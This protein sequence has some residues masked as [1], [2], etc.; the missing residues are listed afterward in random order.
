MTKKY[1]Y[2]CINFICII[3]IIVLF[4]QKSVL[5]N[6]VF[7][8]ISLFFHFVFP[9][10]FIIIII[11]N[12]LVNYNFFYYLNRLLLLLKI[13]NPLNIFISIFSIICGTPTNAIFISDLL[14]NKIIDIKTANNVLK[15]SYFANP[16][17]LYNILCS[18][19]ANQ[20]IV[21]KIIAC[22]YLSNI[23]L[24]FT[25]SNK[26]SNY[27]PYIKPRT[28]SKV[29]INSIKKSI[30]ASLMVLGTICF[31][32]IISNVF[33]VTNN[34]Y[35]RVIGSGIL[36]ITQGLK[37]LS[38]V[39]TSIIKEILALLFISFGG[40]SI[41][42]QVMSCFTQNGILYKDFLNGRISSIVIGMAIYLLLTIIKI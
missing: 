2:P 17:F 38:T 28:F 14:N 3:A 15:Y 19:F 10:L 40:I 13:N 26:T 32:M 8:S 16:L 23:V 31:F 6:A 9:F 24:L 4:I 42:I 22:H 33:V 20:I 27:Y 11:E 30:N 7:E 34:S 1:I 25:T 36:E 41:H 37:L 18:L 12:I 5:E 35:I 29:I 21:F 39:N